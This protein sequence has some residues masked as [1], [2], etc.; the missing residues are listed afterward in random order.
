MKIIHML[1]FSVFSISFIY[2]QEKTLK[3]QALDE[4]KK[5]HY[6]EAIALLEKAAVESP[7]DAEVY[8][9][10][11][12]FNHYRAYDSRPLQGYDFA[13]SEKIFGYLEKAIALN[14]KYGDA[15][16]FYGA[17]CSANAF[18][19]MYDYDLNR[20]KYFY[21]QAF[22]KGAYPAWL[23]EFGK[24][25]MNSCDKNAILFT[26]G[27]ADF[28][29]CMY[30][31]LHQN[32]RT[33]LTVVP[34]G[35]IDRPWY[36]KFLK[37][38]LK[39]GVKK[40]NIRLNDRQIMDIHPFKWDTT[41]VAVH[42]SK[43]MKE[44]FNL[45]ADYQMKWSVEPDLISNRMHAKIESEQAKKR[46]YI[47]PQR[48]ILLHIVEN[49]FA[50]RPVYFSNFAESTFYGGLNSNFQNCGLTSRL[51]P[52]ETGNTDKS[53]DVNKLELLLKS[54]NFKYL[55]TLKTDDIPR[56]SG[57]VF[58]YHIT[59]RLLAQK[60]KQ[61]GQMEKLEK[62]IELYKSSMAIGLDEEYEAEILEEMET[63]R[64]D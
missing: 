64:D 51:T 28:D 27:N 40:I 18:N 23:I 26:G 31:Q 14:P 4:F 55:P 1:V 12:W 33:D 36:V 17:E 54:E 3:E 11:G 63:L 48:A 13:Y 2:A 24:N 49:N 62:L 19:A 25:L 59:F 57:A 45:A 46:I 39:D 60:Y 21:R 10:L 34:L 22:E 6:S 41:E 35:N 47:S 15:K 7:D 9:Y 29:I 61:N 58:I 53:C 52:V 5:E 20:L 50:L 38:G 32:Y 37:N 56:I 8:Y 16:Y 42:V 30:L 43:E 44:E